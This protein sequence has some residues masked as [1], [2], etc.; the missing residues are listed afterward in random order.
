M[1]RIFTF[2]IYLTFGIALGQKSVTESKIN[3]LLEK[4]FSYYGV[5]KDSGQYYFNKIEQIAMAEADTLTVIDMLITSNR[6][7]GYFYDLG[8]IRRNLKKIDVIANEESSFI[9]NLED[10]LLYR[11]SIRADKG[12]FYFKLGDNKKAKTYFTD[13]KNSYNNNPPDSL[14]IEHF[15]LLSNAM[16]FLAKI[17]QLEYKFDLSKDYYNQIIALI[18]RVTPENLNSLNINYALLAEVLAKQ[19]DYSQANS[20]LLTALNDALEQNNNPNRT[21]SFANNLANNYIAL[22]KQDSSRYY[23]NLMENNLV[24]SPSFRE[25][26]HRTKA[27]LEIQ[28][29]NFATA[30]KDIDLALNAYLNFSSELSDETIANI[31]LEKGNIFILMENPRSALIAAEKG[32]KK[33]SDK[34]GTTYLGLMELKI[35]ALLNLEKLNEVTLASREAINILDSLKIEYQYSSDKINLFEK[36]FPL[37][38]STL[39]AN[40]LNFKRTGNPEI[41]NDVFFFIEKSKSVLLME[42]LKASKADQFGQVPDSLIEKERLLRF[43]ITLMEKEFENNINGVTEIKNKIFD[44]KE[45]QAG[46]IKMISTNYPDYYSLRYDNSTVDYNIFSDSLGNDDSMISYFYGNKAIYALLVNSN[47]KNI[48]RIPIDSELETSIIKVYR[49]LSDPKSDIAVLGQESYNIYKCLL[50]PILKSHNHKKL[51]IITDGLLNYIPF[52]ALNTNPEGLTY[53]AENHSISYVNSATLLTELQERQ[54]K[55]HTILAFAPSFDGTANVTNINRGKLLPL[56]NNKKEVEQILTSFNGSSFKDAEA[57]LQNFKSHLSSFG[58]VHLATHAIFDDTAP[59]YSYL[60][61]S[62][63]KSQD[64]DLLYVAD[65][66]NL[67]VDADLV[68]LSACESGLGDLKR[69][70]GFMGLARGFFYSGAAS[71]A[72]TLWKINDASSATLMSGFYKNLSRG[73]A[74]DLALQ[75][76]QIEFLNTHR[77]NGLSHPYYWSGFVIS[78]S[79]VPLATSYNWIWI[80]IGTIIL[81]T[82]GFYYF[83]AR[84]KRRA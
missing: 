11:N 49:M 55:E 47:T 28:R 67:K 15:E 44:L 31:Y 27:K 66:Y 12:N 16:S 4:G 76:A 64:E 25:L 65:L 6:H 41:L 33:L 56:P 37:F 72:S 79:T 17:Y 54:P 57:T 5:Q 42:A 40:Y 83:I 73:D 74:K 38:E 13:I 26:F 53:L 34:Y 7:L 78:G 71:I 50:A 43:E 10:S 20:L 22:T 39:E 62:Q 81:L 30:S 8:A 69:G 14:T 36:T 51:V 1:I 68:T 59:E 24:K 58:M 9:K 19:G 84:K 29:G 70:E 46:L 3:T 75:R 48:I 18:K 63:N 52:S 60:A 32:L 23:L 61:F 80:I 2:I 21:L 45:K 77:D 82:G 35:L